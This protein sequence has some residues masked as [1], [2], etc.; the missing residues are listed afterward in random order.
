[1]VADSIIDRRSS[2]GAPLYCHR[3]GVQEVLHLSG[4]VEHT[5]VWSIFDFQS[6]WVDQEKLHSSPL[7][8]VHGFGEGLLAIYCII[9]VIHSESH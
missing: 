4:L 8:G 7:C 5:I 3:S 6:C 9:A 1:M 2:A